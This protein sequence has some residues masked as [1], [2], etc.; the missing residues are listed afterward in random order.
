MVAHTWEFFISE[1]GVLAHVF[2]HVCVCMHVCVCVCTHAHAYTHMHI[3]VHV[4]PVLK[5]SDNCSHDV[6]SK[7]PNEC[8]NFPV[9]YGSYCQPYGWAWPWCQKALWILAKLDKDNVVLAIHFIGGLIP[10]LI[11][12]QQL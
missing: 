9:S 7:Q 5:L 2:T 1:V 8:Y 3:C 11:N 6:A 4:C 12:Y 10:R